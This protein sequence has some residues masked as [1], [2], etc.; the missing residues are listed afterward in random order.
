MA[1]RLYN[2]GFYNW[3]FAGAPVSVDLDLFVVERLRKEALRGGE[4]ERTGV[5]FGS[6]TSDSPIRVRITGL[7]PATKD[8]IPAII[9][10]YRKR[11]WAVPVGYYRFRGRDPLRMDET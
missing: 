10:R 3:T 9:T 6:A 1:F 8:R 7:R 2:W 11:R 4:G 5:L